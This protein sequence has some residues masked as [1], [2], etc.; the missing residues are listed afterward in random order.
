[1]SG[2]KNSS[3]TRWWKELKPNNEEKENS[4]DLTVDVD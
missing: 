4:L 3:K 2:K 1:M